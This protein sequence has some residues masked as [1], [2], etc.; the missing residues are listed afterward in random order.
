[1]RSILIFT[2][3]VT[4]LSLTTLGQAPSL[5]PGLE[6]PPEPSLPSGLEKPSEPSLPS[7]LE[8]S[9]EPS[10]PTGL[11]GL[12]TSP[13][14][15][16]NLSNT[17]SASLSSKANV[18]FNATLDSTYGTLLQSNPK[19]DDK[20]LSEIRLKTQWSGSTNSIQYRLTADWV[21]DFLTDSSRIDL[22]NGQ[23][24]IDPREAWISTQPLDYLDL[25]IGRQIA[26]WGTGDLLFISDL[27]PKDWQAL[28]LGRNE[29]Y[30]KAPSDAIKASFF[31]NPINL[32][33]VYTPEFDPDRFVTG[34]RIS[35][36]DTQ[37]E[38][39]QGK[40]SIIRA[41]YPNGNELAVRAHRLF[42]NAE[43][44]LY[45][46]KGF[47]KQPTGFDPS[48][49]QP[50]FPKLDALSASWR[51][52]FAGGI[53]S[54]EAGYYESRD[55]PNG[56]DANIRNSET[57]FLAGF[58]RELATNLTGSFQ[59]YVE[60]IEDFGGLLESLPIGGQTPDRSRTVLTARITQ[61]LMMQDLQLSLF[62]FY[63]PSDQDAY[64]RPNISYTINDH[65]KIN[66]GANLFYGKNRDSF[67]GQFEDS[68][69]AYLSFRRSFN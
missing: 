25:K 3:S 16:S 40:N 11:A 33:I 17:Q 60:R 31:S 10:L 26:T 7:G 21:A 4:L 45:F 58:E 52:P 36:F 32:D 19:S 41:D 28:L 47:W 13:S 42:G 1:M 9:S 22:R 38:S 67:F 8:R 57:R 65:W 29:E 69:N 61:Q 14:R 20:A 24:W 44:A 64:L 12:G 27:F 68:S 48:S 46:Q 62:T 63:S 51:Q 34:E 37:S 55:D 15:D 43:T 23:G 30:L 56:I 6:E 66:A 50:T 54:V 53:A 18:R 49:N 39:I 59:Y 35:Y 2:F 5:P